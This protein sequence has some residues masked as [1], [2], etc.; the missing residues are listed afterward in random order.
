MNTKIT[1]EKD[2]GECRRE[3]DSQIRGFPMEKIV[4]TE[5]IFADGEQKKSTVH[6]TGVPYLKNL[7]SALVRQG[8]VQKRVTSSRLH[9]I[10]QPSRSE[11]LLRR[12]VHRGKE[13]KIV[14]KHRLPCTRVHEMLLQSRLE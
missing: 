11:T 13:T 9:A 3:N 14:Q 5:N 8:C 10:R 7:F 12:S 4:D 2:T 6:K 1:H